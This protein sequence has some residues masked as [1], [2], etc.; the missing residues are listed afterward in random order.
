M[1]KTRKIAAILVA[2]VVGFSRLAGADEERT[3]A[4]LR[5]LRSDLIDPAIAVHHYAPAHALLGATHVIDYAN[6]W[7]ASPAQAL[8]DAEK[9]ARQAVQLDERHPYALWAL[10]LICLW[11]R[12]YDEALGK[13]E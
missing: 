1:G 3:L 13:A 2:D 7:T 10:A 11:V 4:R 9:A 8:E 6:G 5:G 12:R